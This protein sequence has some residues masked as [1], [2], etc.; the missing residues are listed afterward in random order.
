V[1][2][3]QIRTKSRTETVDITGEVRRVVQAS[4]IAEGLCL[5]NC[6]HTTA[7]IAV[8]EHADPDVM[9][10]VSSLLAEL[11]PESAGWR[12]S[13]GNADAHVKSALVGPSK[14][15]PISDGMLVLGTWQGVF[16]C[17]FDGPRS[18]TVQI[19]VVGS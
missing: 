13:E 1:E 10:D 6:P 4:G 16:F 19:Q 11:A 14:A 7:G 5:V 12:H 18:R 3:I 17:E 8:Q 15:L 2:T 9:R